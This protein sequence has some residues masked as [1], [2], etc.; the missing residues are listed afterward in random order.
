M[1]L[2][3][4][5]GRVAVD[6]GSASAP[7][8]AAR[9]ANQSDEGYPVQ[10]CRICQRIAETKKIRWRETA[11]GLAVRIAIGAGGSLLFSWSS[12]LEGIDCH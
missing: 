2:E 1:L 11:L 5:R 9:F 3:R 8:L 6:P 12:V 4:S 10:A 7:G